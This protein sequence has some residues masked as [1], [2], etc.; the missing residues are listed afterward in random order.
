MESSAV[1]TQLLDKYLTQTITAEE[2]ELFLA[3]IRNRK[4]VSELE[5]AV[6]EA[7]GTASFDVSEDPELQEALF[8]RILKLRVVRPAA[9]RVHFLRRT[10]FR[11]A[12]AIILLLGITTAIVLSTRQYKSEK[13]LVKREAPTDIAPGTNRAI[14][15]LGNKTID[16]ATNKTGIIVGN[17][18]SYS[19]GEKIGNPTEYLMLSTPRSGQYQ[20]KLPD[21]SKIWLNSASSARFPSVFSGDKR[22]IEVTGEVYLE[23]VAN[24]K[25]PFIVRTNKSIIQV[26]GT[27]FNLNAY[28]D[29]DVLRTTLIEGSVKVLGESASSVVLKPGEQALQPSGTGGLLDKI[30]VQSADIEKV[31]AWKNG[32][33]NFDGA[34][35]R[36]IMQQLSR[37][38]DL[39]IRYEGQIS[40]RRFRGKVTRDLSLS[41]VLEVL[42]TVDVKFKLEGRTLIVIGK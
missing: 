32:L 21:G 2:Q 17:D 20:A 12:A 8:Q 31:L 23:V 1:F 14:L 27:S 29:G 18:I 19:D 25:W 13:D 5:T 34:D 11:Y 38:Y 30:I 24:K 16:L 41:Q 35:V 9:H 3:L 22:E 4:N 7:L 15:T 36:S 26:L 37:W 33:F 28:G 6:A 42:E 39:T 10:W 40:D